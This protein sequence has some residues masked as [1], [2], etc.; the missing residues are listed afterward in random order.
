MSLVNLNKEVMCQ[1]RSCMRL[2]RC[3]S[4]VPNRHNI[5]PL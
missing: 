1:L 2:P 4:S 5:L 3:S